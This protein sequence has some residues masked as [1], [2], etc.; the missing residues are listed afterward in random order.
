MI[1]LPKFAKIDSARNSLAWCSR[2]QD[3]QWLQM[4]ALYASTRLGV[5]RATSN[6]RKRPVCLTVEVK[7]S[8]KA[9]AQ[10]E[11]VCKLQGRYLGAWIAVGLRRG[12]DGTQDQ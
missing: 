7:P 12:E 9:L 10:L 3:D 5:D 11:S 8:E 4:P 6:A 2:G 1:G